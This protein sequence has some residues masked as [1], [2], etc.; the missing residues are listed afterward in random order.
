MNTNLVNL[1]QAATDQI[2]LDLIDK[3]L[4]PG[5]AF[6][7]MSSTSLAEIFMDESFAHDG[8]E[9]DPATLPA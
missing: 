9:D 5:E 8:V 7:A 6:D 4:T 1:N 3:G 2:T